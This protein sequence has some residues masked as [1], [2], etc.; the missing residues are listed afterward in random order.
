MRSFFKQGILGGGIL[1]TSL[2]Y[3]SLKVHRVYADQAEQEAEMGKPRPQI[4][5][6]RRWKEESQSLG[7]FLKGI[8][9]PAIAT[10]F[11]DAI[12][13][14]NDLS[15]QLK[16]ENLL[17]VTDKTML[18]SNV[19]SVQLG[20]EE[21]ECKT[22]GGRKKFM[23]S[24]FETEEEGE[25]RITVQCRLFQRGPG[26]YTQQSWI[27]DEDDV[28][29]ENMVLKRADDDDVMVKRAYRRLS[30]PGGHIAGGSGAGASGDEGT[31][32]SSWNRVMYGVAGVCTVCLV[33]WLLTSSRGGSASSRDNK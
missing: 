5:E 12:L 16:E 7:P 27:V 15:I 32:E 18:G 30:G 28:L 29:R 17:E 24:A 9:A 13:V 11:V 2:G 22:R 10:F 19:T 25:E 14:K 8:G 23:M 33:T 31:V 3:T 4:G 6:W 20:A 26:W 21:K 1:L